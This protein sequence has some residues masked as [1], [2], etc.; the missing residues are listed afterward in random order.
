MEGGGDALKVAKNGKAGSHQSYPLCNVQVLFQIQAG[1][2]RK[3]PPP[4]SLVARA[5]RTLAVLAGPGK[6]RSEMLTRSLL[7][8]LAEGKAVHHASDL[9]PPFLP[10]SACC[11][12]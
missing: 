1:T 3:A 7:G 4:Q 5:P 6:P 9:R 2:R 12:F 10:Q 11:C 8:L